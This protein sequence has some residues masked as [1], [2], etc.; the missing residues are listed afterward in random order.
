MET[1]GFKG[2]DRTIEKSELYR[3]LSNY[4]RIPIDSIWNEYGM[5]E[6]SSQFY[7]SGV[8][9]PHIGPPWTGIVV[10]DPVTNREALPGQ[11]GMIRII[12]LAN[13]WSVLA[14][15]TQ[16]LA[17]PGSGGEFR[18]IGRDPNALP[19]GCSRAVDEILGASRT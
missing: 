15:Q 6:L 1:G 19:R 9:R 2:R 11:I 13:L 18:L 14:I 3:E 17:L 12:D 4:F 5:T 10:I 8:D 16:D 7:S